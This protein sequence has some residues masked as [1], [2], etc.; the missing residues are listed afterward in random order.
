MSTYELKRNWE[1][2]PCLPQAYSWIGLH[3]SYDSIDP[4]RITSLN[5]SA[6]GLTGV[7]SADIS[8]LMMLQYLDL[9]DNS[10]T[11]SIPKFLSQLQYLRVLNL[12]RN[13]LTGSV[14][15]DLIERSN[16]GTLLLRVDENSNLCGSGSCKKKN[17]IVIPISVILLFIVAAVMWGLWRYQKYKNKGKNANILGW[18][19]RLNIAMEAAQGLEY[20]HN[21]CKPPII[22]RDVK[23]TNILLNENSNAKL[24]D[25]GLSKIFPADGTH[26]SMLGVAGTLGYLDPE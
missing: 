26:V 24:A 16:N 7:I 17:N 4:P 10:L 6:S 14:P 19:A 5:L 25:F 2:D 20:L 21:G 11:G 12:E 13:Q 23:T 22:H 9:S 18:E 8:N 1:G 15:A 3:C